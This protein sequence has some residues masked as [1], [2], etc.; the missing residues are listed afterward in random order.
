MTECCWWCGKPIDGE[1]TTIEVD[2][3]EK[4]VLELPPDVSPQALI[5]GYM[6]RAKM[7]RRAIH[8]ECLVESEAER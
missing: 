2:E 5:E 4:A 1:Y 6:V 3:T 8:N 7:V